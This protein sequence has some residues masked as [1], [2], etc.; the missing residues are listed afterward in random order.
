MS[1]LSL[2]PDDHVDGGEF[3]RGTLQITDARF[4]I[5][6]YKDKDGNPV[7][8]EGEAL[9][10]KMAAI[11]E[12]KNMDSGITLQRPQVFSIGQPSL[13][14]T[15]GLT[16]DGPKI[17]KNCNFH[18][19]MAQLLKVDFP[20][21]RIVITNIQEMLVGLVAHWDETTHPN[22]NKVVWPLEIYNLPGSSQAPS[23][24]AVIPAPTPAPTPA[25]APEPVPA[26]ADV[27]QIGVQAVQKMIASSPSEATRQKL[28]ANIFLM[29]GEEYSEDQLFAL[30][31]VIY[32]EAFVKALADAGIHMDGEMFCLS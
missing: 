24:G 6:E 10:P 29:R 7:I 19:F 8:Y 25:P 11:L 23:N 12:L 15:D 27:L 17:N 2:N 21:D 22:G 20:K 14:T 3:P 16:L 1:P 13:Y 5:W 30:M 9:P 32:E 28:N 4:G 18:K 26:G 31:N